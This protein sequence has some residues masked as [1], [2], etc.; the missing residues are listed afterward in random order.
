LGS[1]LTETAVPGPIDRLMRH[2]LPEVAQQLELELSIEGKRRLT[3]VIL[4]IHLG[5]VI[6]Q[7]PSA[8]QQLIL[9]APD[10]RIDYS[11]GGAG[12]VC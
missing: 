9:R 7:L 1:V 8:D 2:R 5:G 12:P 3:A 4:P 11:F 6:W 10:H